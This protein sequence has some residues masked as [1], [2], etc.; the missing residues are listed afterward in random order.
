MKSLS[1]ALDMP[2]LAIDNKPPAV[3]DMLPISGELTEQEKQAEDDF[4]R[5][6][7]TL[8]DIIEQGTEALQ[9]IMAVATGSQQPHAYE[10]VSKIIKEVAEANQGLLALH[11]SR[12]AL[13]PAKEEKETNNPINNN[14]IIVSSPAELLDLVYQ[15]RKMM[16]ES[17]DKSED[18]E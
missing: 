1:Q 12:R 11:E 4:Q 6:R 3:V 15:K 16:Q 8:I 9:G 10:I 13:T 5:S 2:P 18:I 14:T 17:N 7:N